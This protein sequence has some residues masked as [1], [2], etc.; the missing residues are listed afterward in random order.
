MH[1]FKNIGRFV[2]VG[3]ML[4]TNS[5]VLQQVYTHVLPTQVIYDGLLDQFSV[6]AL[7]GHF[8][9]M[10]PGTVIPEYNC[11]IADTPFGHYIRFEEKI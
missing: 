8:R 9:D 6:T 2:I 7:S 1:D 3:E 4:R 11:I 5:H 10:E